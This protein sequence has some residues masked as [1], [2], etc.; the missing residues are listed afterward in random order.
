MKL[1]EKITII[2]VFLQAQR[3]SKP[4]KEQYPDIP[5]RNIAGLRDVLIHDYMGLESVWNVA[6]MIC[7]HSK[8]N[9]A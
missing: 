2:C 9:L 1:Q 3:L 7:R 6:K 8:N 5:W 4:L